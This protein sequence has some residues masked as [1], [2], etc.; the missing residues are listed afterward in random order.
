MFNVFA[1]IK[2]KENQKSKIEKHEEFIVVTNRGREVRVV[3]SVLAVSISDIG[4]RL[5]NTAIK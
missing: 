4:N 3:A 1:I 2:T 5:A